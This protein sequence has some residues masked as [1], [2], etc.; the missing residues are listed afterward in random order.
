MA[1]LPELSKGGDLIMSI[2]I[3]NSNA[4]IKE[5]ETKNAHKYA[6]CEKDLR[7]AWY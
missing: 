2:Q 1:T 4:P 3:C 7:E 6:S 5:S